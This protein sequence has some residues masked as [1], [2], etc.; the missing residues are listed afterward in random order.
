MHD[1]SERG[2]LI[3]HTDYGPREEPNY[4]ADWRG[5]YLAARL[6]SHVG[7]KRR[8]NEDACLLCAPEDVQLA[9]RKGLL[10]AVADGMG[11]ASAGE[12]ASRMA[13]GQ[14]TRAYFNGATGALPDQ[15]RRAIEV[16][17]LR[18][19]EEAEINPALEGMGTTVSCV[20]I[21]DNYAFIGQVGDS[22]VY[23]LR[24]HRGLCQLTSDHSLV[25]EQVRTGLITEEEARHHALKNFITRAVGIKND[26]KV[27]LFALEL[28]H[29]DRLLIC[30]DGLN[31]MV[32]DQEIADGLGLPDVARATD[33]LLELALERGGVDNITILTI[34][35]TGEP[36][37]GVYE[38]GAQQVALPDTG[39]LGRLKKIFR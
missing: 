10:F 17:N 21:R 12:F 19:H 26:V 39:I 9:T 16:A 4:E 30:S 34:D 20:V 24:P 31:N 37:Q 29:G 6:T 15:L 8:N 25:A 38:N 14:L 33:H 22:R 18:I 36:P 2:L 28:H 11:G 5:D 23:L 1:R 13:L 27:D 3:P 32:D 35:V 7:R